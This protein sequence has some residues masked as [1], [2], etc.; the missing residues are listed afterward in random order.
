[1]DKPVRYTG[2]RTAKS[3]G[4]DIVFDSFGDPADPAILLVMGL[5]DQM[6]TWHED[7]CT[8]IAKQGFH[9]IRFDNRDIGLSTRFVQYG[10]PDVV[11][12]AAKK[13]LGLHPRTPYTLTDMARDGMSVLDAAGVGSACVVGASMGGMIAQ[14]MAIEHPDRVSALV[15]TISSGQLVPGASMLLSFAAWNLKNLL[16]NGGAR[17]PFSPSAGALSFIFKDPPRDRDGFADY[18]A[19]LERALVGPGYTADSD[20]TRE[21]AK[22]LYDRG[23]SPDG[24]MRQL[25]GI[26]ASKS[27]IGDLKKLRVPTLVIHGDSD[28]LIPVWLGVQ[29]AK[30]IPGAKLKVF[31]GLG[32]WLPP[33]MWPEFAGLLA[34]F[35][36]RK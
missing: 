32:H 5:G 30:L 33:A 28:P 35:T 11:T 6:I 1:M 17:L 29:T 10:V 8:M 15:S 27:R 12:I 19:S 16:G 31:P 9:V 13:M 18:Y 34:D 24:T 26:L 7:L 14:V 22:R 36:G 3:K 21:F 23:L 25:A 2:P 4:A 20:K